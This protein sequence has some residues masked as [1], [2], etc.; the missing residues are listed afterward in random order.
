MHS[1]SE[2][3]VFPAN[4]ESKKIAVIGVGRTAGK[5]VPAVAGIVDVE[6]GGVVAAVEG[7]GGRSVFKLGTS[8]L[9]ELAERE[10]GADELFEGEEAGGVVHSEGQ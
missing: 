10:V 2:I 6:C 5:A 3:D 9:G 1:G 4:V 8:E 7:T